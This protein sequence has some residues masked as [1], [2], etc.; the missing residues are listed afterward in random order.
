ME[1]TD[2]LGLGWESTWSSGISSR[3]SWTENDGRVTSC[4]K[5]GES[6]AEEGTM[7][8]GQVGAVN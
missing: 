7:D 8:D 3:I 5:T 2:R 1:Y 4:R 6:Q